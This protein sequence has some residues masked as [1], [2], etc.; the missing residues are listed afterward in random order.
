MQERVYLN[1][2]LASTAWL[3]DHLDNSRIRT[4]EVVGPMVP[5]RPKGRVKGSALL[6][7]GKE[8]LQ[9][10][11][12]DF[13][14]RIQFEKLMGRLAISNDTTVVFYSVLKEFATFAFWLFKYYGHGDAR[15]LDGG[16]QKWTAENR[17]L[18]KE[19]DP[20]AAR[21][22]SYYEVV[23][24]D[25]GI[26]AKR[27]YVLSKVGDKGVVFV[28]ARSPREYH[29]ELGS[30]PSW[31][32]EGMHVSGHIPG[33]INIPFEENTKSNG[34]FKLIDELGKVYGP[35][36]VTQD[37]EVIVYCRSGQQSSHTWFALTQLLGYSNVK[38]YDGSWTEWGNLVGV[39]VEL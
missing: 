38:V 19:G 17:P 20:A 12:R 13:I 28:D 22:P 25:D 14:D 27:N 6:D 8:L 18:I 29:G 36:G 16:Y 24:T 7:W 4:V 32:Q 5:P 1:H 23:V 2:A 11:K 9:S 33:A 37:K 31:L 21:P 34:T 3:E 10:T 26:R 15:I 30:S 35:K 39:R